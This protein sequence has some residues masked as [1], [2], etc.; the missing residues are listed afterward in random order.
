MNDFWINYPEISMELEEVKNIIK[1]N[2]ENSDK[3]FKESIYPLIDT[4]G[5]MLRPGFLILSS[6][7]GSFDR[8]KINNLAAAIEM[9]HTATLIHDD[10]IDEAKLRR[11]IETI[12]SKYG[13]D[14]AVYAGDYLFC[15]CFIMLS[16]YNYT[17]EN[18]RDI[19]TAIS[20]I[21]MG[22]IKQYNIR[23]STKT[24]I[25]NY[26]KI[27][28][29]KTAALF[30]ICFYVGAKEANCTKEVADL[31]GKIG[32]H[33]G[34][35]FQIIDDLLD[36]CGD[37]I[38]LGKNTKS[39]LIKGY[40][41]LPLICAMNEDKEGKIKKLLEKSNL[42]DKEVFDIIQLVKKYKGIEKA[43][44]LADKFTKKAFNNIERLPDVESKAILKEVTQRLL[45]RNY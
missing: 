22:E 4:G 5:K 16:K 6:K 15:Q 39:D 2:L 37:D 41:T 18:L 13:K 26:L 24:S 10:I 31:L 38:K 40:Y 43:R 1:S 21:C 11:G 42:C 30:T 14:Y 35:A 17:M 8:E 28:S 44:E 9:I 27:I 29:G 3:Y 45:I 7:F 25:K 34:M 20:K 23:Y 32:Y 19:S 12:Q 33:I 36:Y